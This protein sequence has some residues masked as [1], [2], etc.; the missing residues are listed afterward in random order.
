MRE[1]PFQLVNVFAESH[2]GGNPLA[3]FPDAAGLSDGDML[4][5][6]RQFNLSETVFAFGGSAGAAADLRIFTP[7][8]TGFTGIA[9]DVQC[10]AAIYTMQLDRFGA[11]IQ[12]KIF[13]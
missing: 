6:A 7:G 2:F 5:I 8:G 9:A 10:Y 3:V 1:Y 13:R 11:G 4:Q 12:H